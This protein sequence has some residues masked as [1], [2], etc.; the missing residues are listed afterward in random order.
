MC[1]SDVLDVMLDFVC[2]RMVGGEA[3][4]RKGERIQH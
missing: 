1:V 3:G 4:G 2:G